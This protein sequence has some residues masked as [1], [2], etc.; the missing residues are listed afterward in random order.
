M[1]ITRVNIA[2]R[3]ALAEWL[4]ANAVPKYFSSVTYTDGV[5]QGFDEDGNKILE[6]SSTGGIYA[7]SSADSYQSWTSD[8][9]SLIG[10]RTINL[11]ACDNGIL[12]ENTYYGTGG[13][14]KIMV[15]ITKTN[16]DKTAF[17][18]SGDSSSSG[19]GYYTG[20]RH[21]AW[22][23]SQTVTSTTTFVPEQTNQTELQA[24]LTNVEV[25][26][27]SYT[28]N[29]GYM[30][31]HTLYTSGINKFILG[32]DTYITNGYWYVKDGGAA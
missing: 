1:A 20:L 6:I 10:A 23:D 4:Q 12:F 31:A 21:V 16:N 32:A 14:G 15:A 28:P 27:T 19:K 13:S 26:G 9:F 7:Y 18:F 8:S 29:A 22:G 5:T 25:G 3:E 30:P 24:F 11:I 17:I 2:S